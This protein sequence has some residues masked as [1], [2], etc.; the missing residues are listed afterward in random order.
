MSWWLEPYFFSEASGVEERSAFDTL[1]HLAARLADNL[2]LHQIEW[3]G[4]QS[5][6]PVFAQ[7]SCYQPSW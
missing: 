2:L 5:C 7:L 6:M 3:S 1:V 4:F